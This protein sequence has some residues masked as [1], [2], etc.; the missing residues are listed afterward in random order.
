VSTPAPS[1]SRS[2]LWDGWWSQRAVVRA[3]LLRELQGRFGRHNIGFLWMVVEPLLLASAITV[4][5]TLAGHSGMQSAGMGPYPFSLIGYC[6][7]MIFRNSF[8][9]AEGA[10]PGSAAL[11]YHAQVQPFDIMLAKMAVETIGALSALAILMAAGIMIGLAEL[12]VRPLYLFA[13]MVAITV[14][15]FGLSLMVA[16]FSYKFHVI[17][18]LVHPIAY[19]MFPL[20]G[21]FMTMDFLPPWG[22]EIMAWN[23][24]MTMFETARYGQFHDATDKYIYPEFILVNCAVSL[25]IGIIAIRW[26]RREIQV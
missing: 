17:G 25:L 15:S 22:R 8:T 1:A 9:R 5:H 12:P 2:D 6:L 7:V 3:L 14:W 11:M 16:A 23:P 24:F 18:R 21:A 4:L 19:I 13:A 20:S 10:I 26:L